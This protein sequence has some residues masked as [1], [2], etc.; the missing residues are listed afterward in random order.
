MTSGRIT[1]LIVDDDAKSRELL[2]FHIKTISE[3]ELIG[4]A[5][6][7]V[8][9]YRM[10]L[11]RMPDILF[12]DI[13]MPGK[14]GFDLLDDLRKLEISPCIIFQT[15][16]DKYDIEAIK[17]AAFDYLLKPVHREAILSSLVRFK[18]RVRDQR[19]DERIRDLLSHLNQ[20][21][22]IRFNTRQGFIMFF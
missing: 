7:A 22:K 19:L 4:S 8:G 21:K 2:E 3:I 6:N 17:N 14:S 18:T 10:M 12:L 11:E 15:A 13:E 9:A 20:H 1:A 16:F 5:S